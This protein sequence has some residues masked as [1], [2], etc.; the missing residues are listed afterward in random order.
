MD[1]PGVDDGVGSTDNPPGVCRFTDGASALNAASTR[2]SA[3]SPDD[4]AFVT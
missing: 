4:E 3:G 2:E 1:L